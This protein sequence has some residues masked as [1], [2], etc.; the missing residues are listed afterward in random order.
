MA[1]TT[2]RKMDNAG[3]STVTGYI[4]TFFIAS[5]ILGI[6]IIQNQNLV[7]SY[8]GEV[9]RRALETTGNNIALRITQVDRVI[10]SSGA[11]ASDIGSFNATIGIPLRVGDQVY[12]IA[13]DNDSITLTG[14]TS[15]STQVKIPLNITTPMAGRTIS[16]STGSLALFYDGSRGLLDF[17]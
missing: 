10:A 17:Q 6:A 5:I 7:S 12:T 8:G 4:M 3:V 14:T 11:G 13:L 16:S 1:R 9:A 15:A 2:P